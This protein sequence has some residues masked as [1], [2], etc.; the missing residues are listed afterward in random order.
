MLGV[1]DAKKREL[2]A[3]EKRDRTI[4]QRAQKQYEWGI[5]KRANNQ[6]HFRDPLL[7]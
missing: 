1:T 7:Q 5:N 6:K 4:T 2:R 3:V